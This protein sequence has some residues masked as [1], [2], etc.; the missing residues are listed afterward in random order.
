LL[1]CS[2]MIY[3]I[4]AYYFDF[5]GRC[6]YGGDDPPTRYASY[7]GNYAGSLPK[8]ARIYLLS[9]SI[10]FY[11]SHQ[12]VDFLSHNHAFTN[13]NEAADTLQVKSDTVIIA[14]PNRMEELRNWAD[15]H[16]GGTLHSDYDCSNNILLSYELP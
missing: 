4:W 5:A 12:S 14:T 7:L 6:L 8:N 10:Y 16:P 2:L 9:D 1:L 11:G 3:N 15:A 13:V